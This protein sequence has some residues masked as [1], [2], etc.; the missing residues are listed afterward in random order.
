M[1]M[2]TSLFDILAIMIEIG[3]LTLSNCFS[4]FEYLGLQKRLNILWVKFFVV[5]KKKQGSIR[6]ESPRER[7]RERE[8]G[9]RLSATL[10]LE[11]K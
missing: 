1:E 6:S 11:L 4:N 3:S 10:F 8:Y 2:A 9:M 5:L 7:E